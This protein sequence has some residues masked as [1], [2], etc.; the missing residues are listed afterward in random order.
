LRVARVV[1]GLLML[2]VVK[3]DMETGGWIWGIDGLG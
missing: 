3:M 1:K 2:M